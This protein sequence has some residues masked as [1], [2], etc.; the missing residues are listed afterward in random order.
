MKKMVNRLNLWRE[1]RAYNTYLKLNTRRKAKLPKQLK[2][3]DVFDDV[4]RRIGYVK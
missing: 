4:R 2:I 1:R 3:Y